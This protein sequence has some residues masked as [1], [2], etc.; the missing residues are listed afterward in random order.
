MGYY[1]SIHR[2]LLICSHHLFGESMEKIL[3]A[4][5]EVELI[6][7]WNLEEGIHK[8]IA[9]VHPDVI[10]LADLDPQSD[11]M[12]RLTSTIIEEHPELPV[13]RAGLTENVIRVFSTRL[14]PARGVNLLDVI[15]RLSAP[16]EN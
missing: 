4:E 3:R 16:R 2:V 15:R 11:K 12:I 14:L 7:P 9:V 5:I 6:G 13:I 10:V 1:M 8:Q